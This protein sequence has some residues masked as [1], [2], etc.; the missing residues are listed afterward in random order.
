MK[1]GFV[2]KNTPIKELNKKIEFIDK[3]SI[4]TV[5]RKD[6]V[7]S[8]RQSKEDKIEAVNRHISKV[9]YNLKK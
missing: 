5:F 9:G 1:N 6:V 8:K 7:Q 3:N 4:H 2:N